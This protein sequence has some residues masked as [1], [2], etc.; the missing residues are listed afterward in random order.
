[1]DV[2]PQKRRWRYDCKNSECRAGEAASA[3]RGRWHFSEVVGAAPPDVVRG[4]SRQRSLRE[5]AVLGLLYAFGGGG[6]GAVMRLIGLCVIAGIA[7]SVMLCR[8]D[9]TT[10]PTSITVPHDVIA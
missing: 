8:E 6:S 1:M 10:L 5:R 3:S 7:I 9:S 2:L 4:P